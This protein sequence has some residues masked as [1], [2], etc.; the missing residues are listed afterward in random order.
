MTSA[1]FWSTENG[2]SCAICKR[3]HQPGRGC[4]RWRR[5]TETK[6]RTWLRENRPKE[7]AS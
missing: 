5:W 3:R 6:R 4:P 2:G 7:G 1:L